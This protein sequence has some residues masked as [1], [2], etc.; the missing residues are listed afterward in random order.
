MWEIRWFPGIESNVIDI[1]GRLNL[2][3]TRTHT[4]AHIPP[5][6]EAL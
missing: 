3:H 6:V 5:D 2:L 1:N 4:E